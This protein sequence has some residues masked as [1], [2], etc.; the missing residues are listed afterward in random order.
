MPRL[1]DGTKKK[2]ESRKAEFQQYVSFNINT[3]AW[4]LGQ[5]VIII[6]GLLVQDVF[7]HVWIMHNGHRKLCQ[8][9]MK[10]I[11]HIWVHVY[12]QSRIKNS[13]GKCSLLLHPW[14]KKGLTIPF[15]IL[16]TSCA[17]GLMNNLPALILGTNGLLSSMI[18]FLMKD[19]SSGSS[20]WMV[21]PLRRWK[22]S[23]ISWSIGVMSLGIL[24]PL[25]NFRV[26]CFRLMPWTSSA[27]EHPKSI[28]MCAISS[29][30]KQVAQIVKIFVL[31][32]SI[33]WSCRSCPVDFLTPLLCHTG[34]L[35]MPPN[36]RHGW[37]TSSHPD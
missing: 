13:S 14:N 37:I 7:S 15:K 11:Y 1:S 35:L 4:K 22:L 30:R 31:D 6:K 9:V 12:E 2:M 29:N 16:K 8:I 18:Y 20:C 21:G 3:Q 25:L 32:C 27:F 24:R 10:S 23:A 33:L 28:N 34:A 5:Y 17:W 36:F 26:S 19:T